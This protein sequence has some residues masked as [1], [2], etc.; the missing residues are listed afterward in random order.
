MEMIRLLA[1]YMAA[2]SRAASTIPPSIGDKMDWIICG[3]TAVALVAGSTARPAA[4]MSAAKN[5]M[6]IT[7]NPPYTAPHLAVFPDLADWKRR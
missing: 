2:A 6:A 3:R 5:E 4:P 7:I 1:V